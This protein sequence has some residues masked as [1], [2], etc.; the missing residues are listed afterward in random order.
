M[1]RLN[2]KKVKKNS[3]TGA[4]KEVF[5]MMDQMCY[6]IEARKITSRRGARSARQKARQRP[7][8]VKIA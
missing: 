5:L 1:E 2:E 3:E 6:E 8:Q 7:H 4:G